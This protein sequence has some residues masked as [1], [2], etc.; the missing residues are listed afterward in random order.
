MEFSKF[1]TSTSRTYNTLTFLPMKA[2]AQEE[3]KPA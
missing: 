3:N 2:P 1:E